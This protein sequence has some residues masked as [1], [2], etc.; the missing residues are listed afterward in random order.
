MARWCGA[1]PPD[2]APPRRRPARPRGHAV[3]R[4]LGVR[5]QRRGRRQ[6]PQRRARRAGH[7]RPDRGRGAARSWPTWPPTSAVEAVEIDTGERTLE[8]T[9]GDLGLSVDRGRHRRRRARRGPR[10]QRPGPPLDLG[11]LVRLAARGR[12]D[13]RRP[14][15]PAR[16]SSWPRSR[17]TTAR[18][19][20]EPSIVASPDAVT[21]EP[22]QAGLALDPAVVQDKLMEAAAPGRGPH[23]HRGRARRAAPADHRRRGPDAWP[24]GPRTI[25][26]AALHRHRRRQAGD[27]RAG[28]AAQ[29]AGRPGHG[30]RVRDR[31]RRRGHRRRRHRPHRLDGRGRAPGRHASPSTPPGPCRS[32]PPSW[33]WPAA[34]T[35]PPPGSPTP[36]GPARPRSSSSP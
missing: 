13:L 31:V 28:R 12:V 14:R 21:V 6:P 23:H 29:L 1:S 22:G 17:A 10:R 16:P 19:P 8:S 34:A 26:A 24:T 11:R 27:L 2:T 9:A 4:R 3:L 20:V 33:A 5:H 35:T 18:E 36:S 32:P 30:R 25:T 7:R 15:R